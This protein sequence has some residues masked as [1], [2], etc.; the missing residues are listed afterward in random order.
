MVAAI[1]L[2]EMSDIYLL[3]HI[4]PIPHPVEAVVDAGFLLVMLSPA[5]FLFYRPFRRHWEERQRAEIEVRHLSR[6]LINA[7][8]AE[9][10]H[11]A[12][13]L[14]DEFGQLL[15]ALQLGMETLQ[16]S[17]PEENREVRDQLRRL[18]GLAARLG[19]NIRKVTGTLRPAMLDDLGLAAA[20][21]GHLDQFARQSPLLKVDFAVAGEQRRLPPGIGLALYRIVQESL[22]NAVRHGQARRVEVRLS[23]ATRLVE[24]TVTDDGKGFDFEAIRQRSTHHAGIGL[25]GMRERATALGGELQVTSARGE[26]TTIRATLPLPEEET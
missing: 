21:R 4:G 10:A 22:N 12:R 8:E 3:E 9:R 13:E 16:E 2:A 17:L 1:L 7:A 18:N 5:Y 14:H 25:L 23:Y 24:L 11:I 6:Q 19:R 20:L 26:G 15:T